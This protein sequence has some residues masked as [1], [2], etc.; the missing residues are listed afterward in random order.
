MECSFCKKDNPKVIS[1]KF[2]CIHCGIDNTPTSN[3]SHIQRKSYFSLPAGVYKDGLL[4]YNEEKIFSYKDNKLYKTEKNYFHKISHWYNRVNIFPHHPK[5]G[6]INQ[7]L[8]NCAFLSCI[9][10]MV[11]HNPS[12]ILNMMR[13]ERGGHVV[14]RLYDKEKPI[15]FRI[16][17]TTYKGCR[18]K[19][20]WVTMLEKACALLFILKKRKFTPYG[21]QEQKTAE[22]FTDAMTGPTAKESLKALMNLDG[23][24]YNITP[25]RGYS[26]FGVTKVHPALKR[27]NN[28]ISIINDI[29]Q[30]KNEKIIRRE[31]FDDFL[32][33][34]VQKKN[35]NINQKEKFYEDYKD[36]F[37]GKRF[38]GQ[39]SKQQ[40]EIYQKIV[41]AIDK[42]CFV[43]VG[44]SDNI[45]RL[46]K[47]SDNKTLEG[48]A[49]GLAGPHGYAVIKSEKMSPHKCDDV[50]GILLYNPWGMDN[51]YGREY[52]SD[53]NGVWKARATKKTFFTLELSDL[54]KRFASYFIS[55]SFQDKKL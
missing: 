30:H 8:F 33:R 22:N 25:E 13:D 5:I 55:D 11:E 48:K 1:K 34:Q 54:T 31:Y 29:C 6:D 51:P 44:S 38:T 3:L 9:A 26:G 41:N 15:Y 18:H 32:G 2:I 46:D 28:N 7:K 40:I 10:L 49:R 36:Y 19:A 24:D 43:V 50:Y 39:Y 53:N 35:L 37:P 12:Y 47:N 21:N 14:V 23:I 16:E 52:Y 20:P 4:S 17:K 45:G 42:N 27:E